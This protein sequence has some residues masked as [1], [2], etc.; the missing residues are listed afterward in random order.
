LRVE[1]SNGVYKVTNDMTT[2]IYWR[3]RG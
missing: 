2:S 3:L 1:C